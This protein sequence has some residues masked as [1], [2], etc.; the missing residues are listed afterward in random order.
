MVGMCKAQ[1]PREPAGRCTPQLHTAEQAAIT[2]RA[3]KTQAELAFP[4]VK[5]ALDFKLRKNVANP[6]ATAISK[7]VKDLGEVWVALP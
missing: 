1:A 2:D 6:L 4:H 3:I 7:R 5:M